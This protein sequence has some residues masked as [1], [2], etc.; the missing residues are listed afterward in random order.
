MKTKILIPLVALL[1][2]VFAACAETPKP[3]TFCRFVP[4]RADDFAWE[5]DKIAFRAYGPALKE[6]GEDSGF[7]CWLKRVDYPIVNKWYKENTEGKSYH[8]DHG[9]GYDP[10]KVGSSRGCGG[11]ALWIDG[12]MEISNVFTDSKVIKCTPEESVF[13]LSYEYKVGGDTYTEEKEIS[14]KLGDRLFK[15]TSTFKK[16]GK[17]AADLPIAIGLVRHHKTDLVSKDLEKG[18]MAIWEPMDDSEL[19]TGVVIDPKRI[20]DFQLLETGKTLE[21]HALIITK[22]DAAGQLEYYAGYGW[23]KAGEI[24]TSK[25]WN[26]YLT[27]FSKGL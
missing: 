20:A 13:V 7:D 8:K 25:E 22:T 21:D 23:K 4:E 9:E 6:K 5:N 17:I 10:Y 18:W 19:G 3:A 15:S 1:G 24:K 26:T 2:V 16:N 11:L 14:I 12:K 27:D